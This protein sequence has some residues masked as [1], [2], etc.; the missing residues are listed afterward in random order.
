M[1]T[2]VE[3]RTRQ[4][5]AGVS[6][7]VRRLEKERRQYARPSNEGDVE[8]PTATAWRAGIAEGLRLAQLAIRKG[9]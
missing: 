2:A 9:V 7:L 4:P 1:G 8:A 5:N 3:G 6:R